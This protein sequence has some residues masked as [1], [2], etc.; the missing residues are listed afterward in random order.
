MVDAAVETTILGEGI[1]ETTV[2]VG[3]IVTVVESAVCTEYINK[4]TECTLIR[5]QYV[6]IRMY[7]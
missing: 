6:T 2:V 3:A 5:I 1:Q 7:M 4:N